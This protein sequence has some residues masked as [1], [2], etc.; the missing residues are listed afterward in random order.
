MKRIRN[1]LSI[2]LCVAMLFSLTLVFN[3]LADP[4]ALNGESGKWSQFDK[5]VYDVTVSLSLIHI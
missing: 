4:G 1:I 2:V 3:G 5:G